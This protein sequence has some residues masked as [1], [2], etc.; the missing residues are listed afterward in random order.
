MNIEFFSDLD[1]DNQTPSILTIDINENLSIGTLLSKIHE[2]TEI[3]LFTNLMWDG[4]VEKISCRYYYKTGI[5][6]GEFK[7]IQDLEQKIC[8]FPK[9][10]SNKELSLYIDGSV[11]LA[12]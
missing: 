4:N 12:N 2:I 3:P 11:G 5:E 1:Y 6:F 10:G 7:M 8:N 9:N